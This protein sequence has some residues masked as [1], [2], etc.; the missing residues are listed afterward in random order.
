M[1]RFNQ[2]RTRRH[3]PEMDLYHFGRFW[4]AGFFS[5]YGLKK[6]RFKGVGWLSYPLLAQFRKE[7]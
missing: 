4:V 7:G 5:Q 1:A 2:V 3:E 6:V